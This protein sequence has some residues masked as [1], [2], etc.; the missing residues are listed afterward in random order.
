M[1]PWFLAALVAALLAAIPLQAQSLGTPF[2]ANNAAKN[3]KILAEMVLGKTTTANL[4]PCATGEKFG[5]SKKYKVVVVKFGC[6]N[7]VGDIASFEIGRA[8]CRERV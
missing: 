8:S 2:V 5:Y 1:R 4:Q 6:A 7:P 3:P